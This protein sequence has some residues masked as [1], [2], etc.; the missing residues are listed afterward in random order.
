MCSS[1]LFPSHDRPPCFNFLNT[2]G[3]PTFLPAGIFPI[4]LSRLVHV[5]KLFRI[6]DETFANPV[7]VP[8]VIYITKIVGINI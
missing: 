5:V 2:I 1:D 8:S 7:D 4:V 6:R 3:D